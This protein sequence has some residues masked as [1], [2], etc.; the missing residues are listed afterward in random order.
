MRSNAQAL[1]DQGNEQQVYHGRA[2]KPPAY[3]AAFDSST[4]MLRATARFL[5]GHDF[6]QLGTHLS[7]DWLFEPVARGIN[8]LPARLREYIYKLSGATEAIAPEQA[9]NV[10]A[11]EVARWVVAQYPARRYP[12]VAIGSSN[13]ALVHLYAALGIPWLPQTFLTPIKARIPVDEPGRSIQKLRAAGERLLVANPDLQ[14]HHMHDPAQD[15]LMLSRMAYF[16]LKRL[17]LGEAYTR[18]LQTS[19]APGAT[20]FVVDCTQSWP[21]AQISERYYFQMGAVGG[22]TTGE[23][24]AGSERV[25]A[26]LQHEGSERRR[27]DSPTPDTCMPE[28]EWGF[29]PALLGDI[30]RLAEQR[31]WHVQ[32]L[33]FAEPAAISPLVADFYRWW[34]RQR[35]LPDDRLLAESFVLLEPYWALRTGSVPFWLTFNTEPDAQALDSYLK[36][37][38]PFAELYLMLFSNGVDAPGLA[39]IGRWQSLLR[40]V[41]HG[42]FIGVDTRTYPRDF[43]VFVRYHAALK[44]AISARYPLPSPLTLAQWSTFWEETASQY[45]VQQHIVK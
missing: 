18:F 28:A 12:A 17:R 43:A 7:A 30:E 23:Y 31:H 22:P 24:L 19:L 39:S 45:H 32:R 14:L 21:V 27:W 10:D 41:R 6:P 3:L 26:F 25:A 42:A 8:A 4:A 34:Y 9:G 29:E 38:G 40:Q 37:A 15:R 35:G 2:S 16:R 33:V 1:H 20:I 11:E 13:G 44:R 36:Q 5:H